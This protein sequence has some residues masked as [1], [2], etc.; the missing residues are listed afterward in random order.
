MAL[1][2][3]PPEGD[4]EDIASDLLIFRASD[5]EAPAGQGEVFVALAWTS[6]RVDLG[7]EVDRPEMRWTSARV[8]RKALATSGS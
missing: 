4:E 2:P 5:G 8:C 1:D 3:P 6:G 7:I